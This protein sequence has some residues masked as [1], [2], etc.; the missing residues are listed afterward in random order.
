MKKTIIIASAFLLILISGIIIPKIVIKDYYDEFNDTSE[1]YKCA[2]E[3][4]EALLNP[5][6]KLITTKIAVT[7]RG[8]LTF[9]NVYTLFGV[10]YADAEISCPEGSGQIDRVWFN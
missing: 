6:E 1:E 10:K 9:L 3:H 4:T 5:I 7:G 8:F 2:K